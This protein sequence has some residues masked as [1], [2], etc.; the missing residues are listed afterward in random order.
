MGT[1]GSWASPSDHDGRVRGPGSQRTGDRHRSGVL[2]TKVRAAWERHGGLHGPEP[3]EVPAYPEPRC[4]HCWTA[5][6]AMTDGRYAKAFALREPSVLR[7]LQVAAM[8]RRLGRGLG[9]AVEE[10]RHG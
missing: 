9:R 8:M 1:G 3:G 10:V 6:R 2:K 7:G 5:V 4:E